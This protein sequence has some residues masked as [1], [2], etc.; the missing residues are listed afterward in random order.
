M[1]PWSH[2]LSQVHFH[3]FSPQGNESIKLTCYKSKTCV[4]IIALNT[5]LSEGHFLCSA[6]SF[7]AG[8]RWVFYGPTDPGAWSW[9]RNGAP[10]IPVRLLFKQ[11]DVVIMPGR[12]L[13]RDAKRCG[14][15]RAVC[16]KTP[17]SPGHFEKDHFTRA[18]TT[19]A[20]GS[21]SE[22]HTACV[23]FPP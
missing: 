14:Y 16:A 13:R 8:H 12:G 20:Y 3:V 23:F 22:N 4:I 15:L 19:L 17:R 18:H 10:H 6:A 21:A 1:L 9:Y 2:T 11:T 7:T 5:M